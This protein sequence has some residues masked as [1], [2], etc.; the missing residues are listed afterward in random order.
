MKDMT[1]VDVYKFWGLLSYLDGKHKSCP[2][3]TNYAPILLSMYWTDSIEEIMGIYDA[4]L[5]ELLL[6]EED[7]RKQLNY[8]L[9]ISIKHLFDNNS[10]VT[11]EFAYVCLANL[12]EA[13]NHDPIYHHIT[14][15]SGKIVWD[16]N[17]TNHIYESKHV[18]FKAPFFITK[19]RD[20]DEYK[21][22]IAD[23]ESNIS[24]LNEKGFIKS[25]IEIAVEKKLFKR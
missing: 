12:R 4:I 15:N 8:L 21:S 18:V 5:Q 3:I 25:K 22:F 19:N 10:E 17:D 1:D 11:K 2:D 20:S 9:N 16:E 24:F 13:F 14:I 23:Y 6:S 7:F